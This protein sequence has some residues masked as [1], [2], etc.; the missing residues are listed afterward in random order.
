MKALSW[1][2][3]GLPAT[4]ALCLGCSPAQT[5]PVSS[6]SPP[7][8]DRDGTE[9]R[10]L[11]FSPV[12]PWR[13]SMLADHELV[14][15]IVDVETGRTLTPDE[16]LR[17][18]AGARYVLLGERHDHPDHHT[19]QAWVVRHLLEEGRKPIVAFEMFDRRD[20]AAIDEHFRARPAD[21]FGLGNAVD[22]EA[23]GWPDWSMYAEIVEAAVAGGAP[24]VGANLSRDAVMAAARTGIV[25]VDGREQL[26]PELP[27]EQMSAMRD[28]LYE[29]HCRHLPKEMM[30]KMAVAQVA[31]DATL[32]RTMLAA[33]RGDG[34]VL[35]T[36]NG[37]ARTDRGVPWHLRE[38]G[39]KG[40]IAAVGMLEVRKDE[41]D[42]AAY[43]EDDSPPPYDFVWFTPGLERGDPCEA[44][45]KKG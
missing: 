36:G 19:R 3:V 16:L 40:T 21:A 41:T 5:A 4:L 20:Q 26:L 12:V 7:A 11:P 34:A 6:P 15:R 38:Q 33:D 44:F 17:A 1:L 22:W 42:L 31:R 9:H 39:A 14:G 25:E 13:A 30:G 45:R 32:A 2:T 23:K 10:V 8:P 24:I 43:G 37:H 27:S 18:L 35:V 29:A 28:E